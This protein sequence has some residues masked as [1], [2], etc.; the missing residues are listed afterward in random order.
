MRGF[1]SQAIYSSFGRCAVGKDREKQCA[2]CGTT[3]V[4]SYGTKPI[5]CPV[6]G[7]KWWDKPADEFNLFML[8]NDYISSGRQPEKLSL[9]YEGL[10]R[11]SENLIKKNL[12]GKAVLDPERI[13]EQ[14]E[15][16]ALNF[17]EVYLKKEDYVVEFSFGGLLRRYVNGVMYNGHEKIND[18][19]VS[20]DMTIAEDMKFEDNMFRFMETS[21]VKEDFELDAYMEYEKAHPEELSDDLISIIKRKKDKISKTEGPVNALLFLIAVRCFLAR[22]RKCSID[23]FYDYYG[24]G[25][26]LDIDDCFEI[27]R[28]RL[29]YGK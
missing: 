21:P 2:N 25:L 7:N 14:A 5:V 23:E 15:D 29:K 22:T 12:K 11:Y 6:C 27:I 24:D 17:L 16:T 28:R 13:H 10:I 19:T 26:K 9:M 3:V 20:L 8:Q 18:S 1:P 4:Y